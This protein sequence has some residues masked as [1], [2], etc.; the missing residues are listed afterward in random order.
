MNEK[1]QVLDKGVCMGI[2]CQSSSH[3]PSVVQSQR[4]HVLPGMT[5]LHSQ[6]PVLQKKGKRAP[7]P[8]LSLTQA[9]IIGDKN[10][11]LRNSECLRA[12]MVWLWYALM[13]LWE[14]PL[15]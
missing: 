15:G 6:P 2:M 5:A 1:L 11:L 4:C 13:V 9:P 14:S 8:V 12:E 3:A 10:H 7:L